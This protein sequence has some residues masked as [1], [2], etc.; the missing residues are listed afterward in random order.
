MNINKMTMD[1][2]IALAQKLLISIAE[3]EI[4]WECSPGL[5]QWLHDVA[6]ELGERVA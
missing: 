5:C 3:D 1:E 4:G 6:E 2:R